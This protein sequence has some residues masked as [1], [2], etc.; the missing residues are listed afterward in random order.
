M[1]AVG[2]V[3]GLIRR[4]VTRDLFWYKALVASMENPKT[5][6]RQISSSRS[7]VGGPNGFSTRAFSRELLA[8]KVT[9][10]RMSRENLSRKIA[11]LEEIS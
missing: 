11:K 9:F 7:S 8:K 3:Q 10:A 5:G 2:P 6:V 4:G 1:L